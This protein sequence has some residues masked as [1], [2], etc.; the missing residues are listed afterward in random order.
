MGY[1]HDFRFIK[2]D[3]IDPNMAFIQNADNFLFCIYFNYLER[4]E[5]NIK[6]ERNRLLADLF[7]DIKS[8]LMGGGMNL[9]TKRD[10]KE[11]V[12]EILEEKDEAERKNK[13]RSLEFHNNM[14][15]MHPHVLDELIKL[16]FSNRSFN[17]SETQVNL[18][19]YCILINGLAKTK[20]EKFDQIK[21]EMLPLIKILKEIFS[22]FDNNEIHKE[23][24]FI[25]TLRSP[26]GYHDDFYIINNKDD[27]LRTYNDGFDGEDLKS[28]FLSS[29]NRYAFDEKCYL[30]DGEK[31]HEL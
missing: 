21:E 5:S 25:F 30:H 11:K 9:G 17:F 18:I 23:R 28:M 8:S 14:A 16:K 12:K 20:G 26:A 15:F 19:L 13:L 1:D 10:I 2:D 31:K 6:E 22:E 24:T 3:L 4:Y 27:I 7:R 29:R